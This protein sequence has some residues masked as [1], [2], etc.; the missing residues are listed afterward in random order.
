MFK[1]KRKRLD[2][3]EKQV[4]CVMVSKEAERLKKSYMTT[5]SEKMYK[6]ITK[7]NK[8]LEKVSNL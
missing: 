6:R 4:L 1:F 7:L 3:S 2:C 8:L 5:P